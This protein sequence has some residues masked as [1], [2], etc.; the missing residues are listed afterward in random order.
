MDVCNSYFSLFADESCK[1]LDASAF[2]ESFQVDEGDKHR[3]CPC[4]MSGSEIRT[5]LEL[6]YFFSLNCLSEEV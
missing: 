5:V 1:E 4:L 6:V 3:N 2:K